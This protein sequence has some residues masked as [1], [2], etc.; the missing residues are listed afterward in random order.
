M[1]GCGVHDEAVIANGNTDLLVLE[2]MIYVE[3][4]KGF[5]HVNCSPF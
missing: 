5:K 3:S 1:W 2:G 4:E